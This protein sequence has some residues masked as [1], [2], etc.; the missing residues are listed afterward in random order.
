MKNMFYLQR[1][2]KWGLLYQTASRVALI[3]QSTSELFGVKKHK[4]SGIDALMFRANNGTYMKRSD[5]RCNI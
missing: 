5:V 3:S 1:M 2:K 4:Q